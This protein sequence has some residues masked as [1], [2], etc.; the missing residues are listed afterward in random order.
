MN[1]DEIVVVTKKSTTKKSTATKSTATKSAKNTE[2][3]TKNV[4]KTSKLVQTGI[5]L[6]GKFVKFTNGSTKPIKLANYSIRSALNT[7][8]GFVFEQR[9]GGDDDDGDK[10]LKINPKDEII[11]FFNKPTKRELEQHHNK[12]DDDHTKHVFDLHNDDIFDKDEASDKVGE[13]CDNLGRVIAKFEF[14]RK[15]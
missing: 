12:E 15:K 10:E 14:S 2:K 1:N 3:G 4:D 9:D 11:I 5:G 7:Q 13:L 6:D 8:N